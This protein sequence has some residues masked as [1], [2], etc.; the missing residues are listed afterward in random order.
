MP[1]AEESLQFYPE[2]LRLK[3]TKPLECLGDATVLSMLNFDE[4]SADDDLCEILGPAGNRIPETFE[5][6]DENLSKLGQ[7]MLY[8]TMH[9]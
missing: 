4:L 3:S 8:D 1:K 5:R 7:R 9:L 2:Q 6:F